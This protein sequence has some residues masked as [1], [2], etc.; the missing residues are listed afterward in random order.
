MQFRHAVGILILLVKQQRLA[1]QRQRLRRPGFV[2]L[3]QQLKRRFQTAG[4]KVQHGSTIHRI[5]RASRTA[6][7]PRKQ[8]MIAVP[9]RTLRRAT[10]SAART[11]SVVHPASAAEL[12]LVTQGAARVV[13]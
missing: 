12:V 11:I 5:A 1:H 7:A 6:T 2:P 4:V 3:L 8:S 9:V 10:R 13:V